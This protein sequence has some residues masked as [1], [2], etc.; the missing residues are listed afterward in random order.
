MNL[1]EKLQ[2]TQ[3][4]A[5]QNLIRSKER[6]KYYYDKRISPMRLKEGDFVFLLKESIRRK[7]WDQYTGPYKVLKILPNN[8]IKILYR[9]TTRIAHINKLKVSHIDLG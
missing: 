4:D 7:F 9:N 5:R 1:F 2:E 3:E 8:N 6:N